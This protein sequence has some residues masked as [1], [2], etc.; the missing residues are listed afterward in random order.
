MKQVSLFLVIITT[1][2]FVAC[3]SVPSDGYENEITGT[4]YTQ[5]KRST[6]QVSAKEDHYYGK[7]INLKRPL[8]RDGD[9]KLDFRNPDPDE[10]TNLL[11][12]TKVLHNVR[13]KG[14]KVWEGVFYNYQTGKDHDVK[15]SLTEEGNLF[16]ESP[17]LER[18]MTWR[19]E[20][21]VGT[22]N[23]E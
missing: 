22:S 7:I 10:K 18:D 17:D 23:A 15:I 5:G 19:S 12:E 11:K 6:I 3:T 4:W 16:L 21:P 13:Y 20:Y 14:D 8:T 1:S 9:P 2:F